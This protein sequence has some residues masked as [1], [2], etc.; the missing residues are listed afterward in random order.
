MSTLADARIRQVSGGSALRASTSSKHADWTATRLADDWATWA[1]DD[2]L[3]C[4]PQLA[5]LDRRLEA[6]RRRE[7][8]T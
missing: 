5:P 2:V 8:A 1:S 7:N 4:R 3:D 6:V